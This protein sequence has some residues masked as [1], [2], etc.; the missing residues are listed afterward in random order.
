MKSPAYL[1]IFP[2]LKSRHPDQIR[3]LCP[4]TY[5]TSPGSD[6]RCLQST[7]FMIY[8]WKCCR[9]DGL[10]ISYQEQFS[11]LSGHASPQSFILLVLRQGETQKGASDSHQLHIDSRRCARSR[12]RGVACNQI[13]SHNCHG[14]SA[15]SVQPIKKLGHEQSTTGLA[16]KARFT[17]PIPLSPGPAL[18]LFIPQSQKFI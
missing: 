9:E 16:R 13:Q 11:K 6:V 12:S 18:L 7:A 3:A 1:R 10:T 2:G 15:S 4:C 14:A 17:V 8:L 5:W